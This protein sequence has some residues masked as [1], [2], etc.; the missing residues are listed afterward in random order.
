MPSRAPRPTGPDRSGRASCRHGRDRRGR[1]RRRGPSASPCGPTIARRRAGRW[2]VAASAIEA[3]LHSPRDPGRPAAVPRAGGPDVRLRRPRRSSSSCISPRPGSTPARSA[4]L[5]TLTLVGDTLI[6]LWLTTHADRIGRRRTLVVG[7][8]PDGRRPASCSPAA[9]AFVVLLVAATLGV[10]SPSGSEVGP[11]LPIEQAS[12][13]EVT[14]G[15][16][17]DEH[18][19]LVQPH[20]LGRDRD[21]RA[22]RR[23]RRRR[24]ARRGLV[25]ASTPTG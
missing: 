23:P 10:L 6:S 14:P 21:G 16:A 2:S 7:A 25:G 19:R 18:L 5:L 9:P 15:R 22:G 13:T 12:L 17:P 24:A 4:L 20:G 3:I 8:A 11:F 1:G